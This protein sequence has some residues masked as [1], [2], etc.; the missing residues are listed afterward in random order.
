MRDESMTMD[1]HIAAAPQL[2]APTL[3]HHEVIKALLPDWILQTPRSGLQ[4]L[5]QLKPDPKRR[6]GQLPPAQQHALNQ[7][8]I[9]HWKSHHRSAQLLE[10]LQ[11]IH[12]FAQPLLIKALNQHYN[13]D[14]ELDLKRT[15]IN[16]YLP[17]KLPLLGLETGAAKNWRVS[18]LDAALHNF[19]AFEGDDDAHTPDSGFITQP[20]TT[21]QYQT[22]EA[23]N[24]QLPVASFIKLCR[25]LDIGKQYKAH[26]DTA[27]GI[28]NP[29]RALSVKTTVRHSLRTA[30]EASM[31]HALAHKDIPQ[32]AYNSLA[33]LG[34]TRGWTH[35]APPTLH[36]YSMVLQGVT[37]TG[38][39]V[40]SYK[41]ALPLN[42]TE[43]V[44]YLPDDPHH[45][46]KHY[47]S[48]DEFVATMAKQL[49]QNDYQQYFSRFIDHKDLGTFFGTLKHTLFK[50]VS[51]T[52]QP[53][54]GRPEDYPIEVIYIP[55]EHPTLSVALFNLDHEYSEYLYLQKHRKI[56]A[57]APLIAV[58]T[59]TEDQKTRHD[60]H[61][62]LKR[63]LEGIVNAV[64][65]VAAIFV[66]VIG[67]LMMLQMAYQ[68]LDDVYEGIQDWAHGK[69]LEAWD[70]L[71]NVVS[72]VVQI[73]ALAIGGKVLS[74]AL[75][76]STSPFINRL[77]PV[78]LPTSE[79]R[80]WEPNLTP[81]EHPAP[82]PKH[83]TPTDI[84]LYHHE[85]AQYLSL[86]GKNYRAE[87]SSHTPGYRI[88]HPTR[89]QAYS[90]RV[91]HNG[92]GAWSAET[93]Q[94]LHWNDAQLFKRLNPTA[95]SFS[96]TLAARILAI[97]QTDPGVLRKMH[98]D[99]LPTP[100]LLSDSIQRFRIDQDIQRFIEHMESADP[101]IQ[102]QADPQTQLQL[103]TSAD[104]WS[105]AKALKVVNEKGETLAQY[106]ASSTP[107]DWI[108]IND[109]ELRQ[110][111][112]LKTLLQALDEN[113]L[114]IL[115]E[116]SPAFADPLPNLAAQTRTLGNLL[117]REARLKRIE[118]FN[119]RYASLDPQANAEV[120]LLQKEHPGLPTKAAQELI[121]H[122]SGDEV[123]Q[124][125]NEKTI[126]TRLQEEARQLLV[127]ARINRAY[128]GLFLDSAASVDSEWLTLKSIE[129][130]PGWS[131]EVR[132]EIR[133][134]H[135]EGTLSNSL[136]NENAPLRKVLVKTGNR[137]SARDALNQELHGPDDLY[138]AL[139]H[140]LPDRE[141]NQLGFPHVGQ[142]GELKTRVRQAPLLDRL[143][144]YLYMDQPPVAEGFKSPMELA[145]GRASYPLLGA[146]APEPS[147]PSIASKVYELYPNLNVVERGR[148]IATLP[149]QESQAMQRLAELEQEVQTL[150]DDMEVW[151]VDAP[152]VNQRTGDL[153]SPLA[154]IAI[155]QDRRA[156]S[157]EL[158]RCWRRQ[159]AF[160]NHYADATRDGFE[161]TFTR[162]ILDN[163]PNISADFSHVTYMSLRGTG[164]VTG[165]NEFLQHFP[166]L[167]VLK[168]QGFALDALPESLFSMQNIT[169]L[170]LEDSNITLTPATAQAFAGLEN[171]EH[172]DLDDNPLGITP[173]FSN[174]QHLDS[175]FLSNTELSEFPTSLLGLSDIETIDLSDNLIINLPS[176]LF[177]APAF[178]TEALDLA[179]NPL[180]EESLNQVRG[181]FSQTG[182]DMNLSFD[183]LD[184]ANIDVDVVELDE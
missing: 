1:T 43:V 35:E 8:H 176:E 170:Y 116:I 178:I 109:A 54:E 71:F 97:T 74:E 114:K 57:D 103:L 79:T 51:P 20:S 46:L 160:D 169:E 10:S 80:L 69:T 88:K 47:S 41:A 121:W 81:Y 68:I 179:G 15:F 13:V 144:V 172:I 31:H 140:A 9:E 26:L 42:T 44:V 18:M 146:D 128:E 101:L 175:V 105:P 48:L 45:P 63:L 150:R 3:I 137:Y 119:S 66:P 166:K 90:P 5:K 182:I 28:N 56:L 184:P 183:G 11:D 134:E 177:E 164:P 153:I 37:L 38:V 30:F 124:L 23:L 112:L 133:E 149:T 84:G 130:L 171:L 32:T 145:H 40:F 159:T 27:L 36:P 142:G 82:L 154:R 14:L 7:A 29:H 17:L 93:E 125:L 86:E 65:F 16:L 62:R 50:A 180:S 167:R 113:E 99:A 52:G 156:F 174:M 173:D 49:R 120:T 135:F 163:M 148:I 131:K 94:P 165:V 83:Q 12:T 70:H 132:I 123:Q 141:R 152:A 39:L 59:D 75:P 2:P 108:H 78:T 104:T 127:Q 138:S 87:M 161:L 106:P 60:R 115:L 55:I 95:A 34:D 147:S 122:A 158:E 107:A 151:T 118:L 143:P 117:A 33:A 21:G 98:A 155:V 72:S 181:Y 100:A 91:R 111:G 6:P 73:G 92:T 64:E 139:L 110:G 162:T 19:E 85:S 22:L 67:E 76:L 25:T 126:P 168:L 24:T 53:L 58:S 89:E 77:K 61:E 136:G 129:A 157:R 4:A 96:D 102:Q